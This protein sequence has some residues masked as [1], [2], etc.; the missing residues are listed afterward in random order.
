[1]KENKLIK[2]NEIVYDRIVDNYEDMHPEIFNPTEQNR[3]YRE[4]KFVRSNIMTKSR[5]Y[6]ALDFGSGTGNLTNIMLNLGFK[7][8]SADVSN[9]CLGEIIKKHCK[10]KDLSTFLLNGKDLSGISNSSIDVVATYS[11]L[12]H[13]PNYLKLIPEFIRVV[14]PGGIIIIEHEVSPNFWISDP[15][16]FKYLL[17]I[18]QDKL[19]NHFKLIGIEISLLDNIKLYIYKA[20]K[21]FK[22]KSWL[23]LF[24]N[25]KNK[26]KEFSDEGDIHVKKSDH[27]EWDYIEKIL[28]NDTEI[29][30][31]EDYLVCRETGRD[32]KIW[33]RWKNN[34]ND[35]RTLIVRKKQ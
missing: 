16:Y 21:I 9:G 29:I 27:I 5:L 31:K 20:S 33:K 17:K 18:G 15:N 13:I 32:L 19:I 35:M 24:Q 22:F 34:T 6:K 12:H 1:M 10:N 14:K 4:F 26:N 2:H 8:I 28:Q 30:K 23:A 7:V 11:V 3:L 25:L